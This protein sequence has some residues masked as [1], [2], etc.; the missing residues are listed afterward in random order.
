MHETA[1]V[2]ERESGP[3]L[4]L[5]LAD[6]WSPGGTV[7]RPDDLDADL[8]LFDQALAGDI[9]SY[10]LRKRY[11]DSRDGTWKTLYAFSASEL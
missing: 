1:F 5:V 3:R 8:E 9:D 11:L 7:C 2:L 4:D 6:E 10:R